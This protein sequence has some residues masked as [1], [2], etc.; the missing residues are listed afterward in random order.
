[1]VNDQELIQRARQGDNVAFGL[2]WSRYE[3]QV[4]S[5]CRRYLA[6]PH[7]DPATDA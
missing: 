1:M 7:R 6:G 4:V 3:T 5:L 2:L